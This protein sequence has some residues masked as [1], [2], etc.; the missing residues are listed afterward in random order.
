MSRRKPPIPLLRHETGERPRVAPI[1]PPDYGFTLVEVLVVI[2]II[3]VL[4]ALLLPAIQAARA[5]AR[6]TQC[7]NQLRQMAL[8]FS[9]HEETHGHLPAG[10]WGALWIGDADRGFGAD[11]PGGWVYNILAYVEQAN[12]R[13]VGR[14]TT[15]RAKLEAGRDLM[16]TTIPMFNCPSRPRD[17]A[18][19]PYVDD[20]FMFNV[21]NMRGRNKQ[22]QTDY[23][24]NGGSN[25]NVDWGAG[26]ESLADAE[27]HD[28]PDNSDRQT[29]II[30]VR[31]TM[32]LREITDGLSKTYMVGEKYLDP[33]LYDDGGDW[34]DDN[35]MYVGYDWDTVRWANADIPPQQDRVSLRVPQAFGSAHPG[36]FHM[37]FCDGSVHA[38]AYDLDL[39]V[40]KRLANRHD[41]ESIDPGHL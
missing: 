4:I 29:G 5:S 21:L 34:G 19:L 37:T 7:Q 16:E 40:H 14:G 10:G 31:S 30:D 11:Q 8:G 32:K 1:A 33:V 38:I 20:G 13:A 17:S 25:D 36:V 15:G 3:G 2:A 41:G 26:P 6:R 9:L 28:W 35:S 12:L 39:I 22:A 23:A 27:D 18:L 24:V